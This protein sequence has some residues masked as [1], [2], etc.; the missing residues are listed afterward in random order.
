MPNPEA[1]KVCHETPTLPS[2]LRNLEVG[3]CSDLPAAAA[4]LSDQQENL[5]LPWSQ[6]E[7]KLASVL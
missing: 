6:G 4:K 7:L 5:Q 1:E 3:N 2:S